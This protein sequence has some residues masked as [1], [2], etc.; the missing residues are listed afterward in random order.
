M[1]REGGFGFLNGGGGVFLSMCGIFGWVG[2]GGILAFCVGPP[3]KIVNIIV[4]IYFM[5]LYL[6]KF[7]TG[8]VWPIL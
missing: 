1:I 4:S 5:I 7:L 2:A 6:F 3:G 8:L